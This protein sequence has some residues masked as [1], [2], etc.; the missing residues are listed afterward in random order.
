MPRKICEIAAE[1][2]KDWG[3]KVSPYAKPY[4]DA[5]STLSGINDRYYYDDAKTII[6]YFLSNASGWRGEV[7]KRVK[8]ELKTMVGLK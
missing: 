1:V 8:K 3:A 4:L 7:A 2:K 6:L 5:M